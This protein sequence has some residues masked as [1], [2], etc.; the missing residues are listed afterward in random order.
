LVALLQEQG[1]GRGE[2]SAGK[3]AWQAG[4]AFATHEPAAVAEAAHCSGAVCLL[5]HPGRGD[6]FVT[7]D[8][9]LLDQF[10]REVAIDGLEVYYPRHTPAQTAAYRQYARRHQLLMSAGSDSHGLDQPPIKYRAEW[11]RDLLERVGIQL[12]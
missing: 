1:Y 8:L 10:R 11:S 2:P 3:M 4:L 9:S 12:E 5:A 6:G 7:Y